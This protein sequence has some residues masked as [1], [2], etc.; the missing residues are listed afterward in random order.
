MARGK[1][2]SN[3]STLVEL[4]VKELKQSVKRLQALMDEAPIG[5]CNT[6]LKGKI[7]YVNRRFEEVSGYSREEVVGKNGLKLGILSNETVKLLAKRMKDRLMERPPRILEMQFKCKDGHWIWVA[8]EGKPI[9]EQ[10]IPVGFQ[11]ISRDITGHKQAEETL[12]RQEVYFQQ[13]FDDCPDAIALLDTTDRFVNVNKAFEAL[14]GYRAEEIKG[15]PI[16]DIVVPE[17]HMEEASVLSQAVLSGAVMRKEAVRRRKDGSVVDVSTLGYPI[18]F[19]NKMVGVY[20]IY[21]DITERKQAEEELRRAKEQFQALVE[22]S[23]LGVSVIRKDGC[24]QYVNP[25]FVEMF[26]Y[27]LEDVATGREWFAKACPDPEYRKQVI[28]CW[29]TELQR[30][31][32][33]EGRRQTF[34]VTC[35][36]GS[37]KLIYFRPVT[38]ETGDHF[39][40]YEDITERKRAEEAL[41][42]AQERLIRSEKL[43]AIGQLASGVG[44]ELRNP[45]AAIKNAV[46]YVRRKVAKSELSAT[47]PKVLEFLDIID[48]EVNSS[49][50]V[51]TDLL[52]FARVAKPTVSLVNVAS[53]IKDALNHVAM[54]EN[55]RLTIDVDPGLP[56][57]MVDGAQIRQV[58][59]NAILN[60]LEAM[61]EGG[62]LEIRARS[63]AEF[64]TVEF[65][66]TGCGIPESV[67]DKI[68][69]PLFT[70][71]PKGIGLGL[72]MCKSIME[73]HGGDIG[74]KS[75][76]G[77]GTTFT[78]SLPTRVV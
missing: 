6:D 68:F 55:V 4:G 13:L 67:T 26:G 49:N 17:D 42:E 11:I 52:S 16:N 63:K 53:I 15:R 34:T 59:I 27:T 33:G 50:K 32:R 76:E 25:K 28:S 72:A 41:K 64:V 60:A 73:G 9:R 78:L 36:D 18:Q 56:M 24:Y 3:P 7:T 20:A 44:H 22:E 5:I 45:L 51:I 14:F 70:T 38:L 2:T 37:E 47:E 66:D 29:V 40:I 71:K 75:K 21:S 58:F 1:R 19:D 69:D 30:A 12:K 8:I 61:P 43:A 39:V 10:G 57:V 31:K 62:R 46:L 77:K 65:A 35:K 54:S 48:E 23:P 74:V